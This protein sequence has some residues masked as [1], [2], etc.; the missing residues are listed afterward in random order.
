MGSGHFPDEMDDDKTSAYF[1]HVKKYDSKGHA[2]D[3]VTINMIP[4]V[5]K[6]DCYTETDFLPDFN[7]G[8]TFHYGGPSGCIG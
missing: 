8:Y 6:P 3:P 5:D 7:K 4:L 1:R 2:T